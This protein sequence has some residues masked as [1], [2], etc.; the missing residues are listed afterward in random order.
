MK[1]GVIGSGAM[2]SVYGALLADAG[3]DV[4]MFDKWQDHVTAMRTRGLR[5]ATICATRPAK[6]PMTRDSTVAT[7]EKVTPASA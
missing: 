7:T 3:N 5:A 6:A 4:W 2:G 1:I